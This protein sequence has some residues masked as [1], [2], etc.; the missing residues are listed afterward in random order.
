MYGSEAVLKRL[1][2]MKRDLLFTNEHLLVIVAINDSLIIE[3][4][5]VENSELKEL[6]ETFMEDREKTENDQHYLTL[7]NVWYSYLEA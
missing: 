4:S 5:L 1:E 7:M 3:P 6:I 2:L